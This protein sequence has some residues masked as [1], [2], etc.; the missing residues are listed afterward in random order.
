MRKIAI[1]RFCRMGYV[2]LIN[3]ICGNNVSPE[4]TCG[5][6]RDLLFPEW[7]RLWIAAV[8]CQYPVHPVASSF[9]LTSSSLP[10]IEKNNLIFFVC[11]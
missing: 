10:E 7:M 4:H 2:A 3:F 1:F 8:C 6:D 11:K 5:P 9:V